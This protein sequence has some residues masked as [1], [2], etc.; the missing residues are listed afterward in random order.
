MIRFG[1]MPEL[2]RR[3]SLIQ[4]IYAYNS[5]GVSVLQRKAE[6]PIWGELVSDDQ[7]LIYQTGVEDARRDRRYRIRY[8]SDVLDV[9]DASSRP[10]WFIGDGEFVY[11]VREA[12]EDAGRDRRRFVMITCAGGGETVTDFNARN[13]PATA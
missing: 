7:Q 12:A 13:E 5:D 2:D 10:R 6:S 3:L 11:F 8:R 1:H 9:E 4:L